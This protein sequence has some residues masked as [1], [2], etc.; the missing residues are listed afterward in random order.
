[1]TGSGRLTIKSCHFRGRSTGAGRGEDLKAPRR[2]G[3]RPY[4]R[5]EKTW[6]C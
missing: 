3:D 2:G 1:M 5:Q 4:E 6:E